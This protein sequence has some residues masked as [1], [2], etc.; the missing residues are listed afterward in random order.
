MSV[1]LRPI[2]SSLRRHR[3]TAGLL[4]LQVALTCTVLC[5]VLFVVQTRIQRMAVASGVDEPRLSS[6]S[7]E[8]TDPD[9]PLAERIHSDIRLLAGIPGVRQAVAVSGTPIDPGGEDSYGVCSR[10]AAWQAAMKAGSLQGNPDCLIAPQIE[11][12]PGL[13]AALGARLMTGRDFRPE[14]YLGPTEQSI[15]ITRALARRLYGND[16]VL[17][18]L[19]YRGSERP[20]RIVGVLAAVVRPTPKGRISDG[21][22]ML[23]ARW[24]DQNPSIYLLNST[25]DLQSRILGE[26]MAALRRSDPQRIIAAAHAGSFKVHRRQFFHQDR[27]MVHLLLAALGGLL[28][29]TAIGIAGLASFWVADRTRQIGIRRAV[30]APRRSILVYFQAENLLIVALAL[31]PGL[32]GAWLLSRALMRFYE[33]PALPWWYLPLSAVVMVLLGQIS[34]L[35]PAFKAARIPPMVAMRQ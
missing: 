28:L 2:F 7:S 33:L 10:L 1:P 14:E 25:A 20:L 21:Y 31:V 13:I 9:D 17:G 27:S 24:P 16:N 12:S 34:V 19:L 6:L 5:N 30:G 3:L 26:A 11:G 8:D 29:V 23:S 32:G 18:K 15:I 4:I 35:G 22:L